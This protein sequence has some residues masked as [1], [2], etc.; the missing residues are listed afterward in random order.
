MHTTF[1]AGR[2]CG[3]PLGHPFWIPCSPCP[4]TCPST[5]SLACLRLPPL[6]CF[7]LSSCVPTLLYDHLHALCP[8][9]LLTPQTAGMNDW[10]IFCS[11][12]CCILA[13]SRT[14]YYTADLSLFSYLRSIVV[15]PNRRELFSHLRFREYSRLPLRLHRLT[16]STT[17]LPFA[18]A[19]DAAR[20]SPVLSTHTLHAFAPLSL[21]YRP[22]LF[23]S[24]SREQRR[25][26]MRGSLPPPV[27][28]QRLGQW[29]AAA[30]L[31]M[32][33]QDTRGPPESL[34]EPQR[35]HRGAGVRPP[36]RTKRGQEGVKLAAQGRWRP[37]CVGPFLRREGL[38]RPSSQ[39]DV[40]QSQ[41]WPFGGL[42]C[43]AL[44]AVCMGGLGDYRGRHP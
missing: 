11:L 17:R 41:T 23:F 35:R 3:R 24:F 7:M 29:Q 15:S 14:L 33:P 19:A 1:R 30:V 8:L 20:V 39:T 31:L 37:S 34:K 2:F 28:G 22:F 27:P 4:S 36:L 16:A 9:C 5:L 12:A 38:S 6:H 40:Q 18:H 25:A 43:H 44:C 10:M 26:E 13:A 42:L 21:A 32:G